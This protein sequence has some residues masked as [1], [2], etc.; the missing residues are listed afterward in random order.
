MIGQYSL[1]GCKT[2]TGEACVGRTYTIPPLR[3][4]GWPACPVSLLRGSHWQTIVRVWNASL[5]SPLA[6][7]PYG[8]AAWVVDGVEALRAADQR[9][10]TQTAKSKPTNNRTQLPRRRGRGF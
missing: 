7:W 4:R 9:K 3:Y 10:A 8:H 5:V 2:C 1:A 6:D